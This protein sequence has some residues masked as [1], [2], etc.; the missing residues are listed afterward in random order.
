MVKHI[1]LWDFKEELNDEERSVAA[2]NLKDTLEPLSSQI[3][4]V[5]SLK[6]VINE[7]S[8]STKE[9]ALISEFVSE[10]ALNAYQIH[11]LHVE[12]GKYVKTVTKDRVC[13]D[14]EA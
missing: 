10:E 14:F 5:V 7:M 4:G 2:I 12:A 11:P 9:I 1:V 6:V 13:F 3:E 8:G